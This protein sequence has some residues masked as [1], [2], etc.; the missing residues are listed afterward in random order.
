M[1]LEKNINKKRSVDEIISKAKEVHGDK[2]DYSLITREY[3]DKEKMPIL[4]HAISRDG[5][6]HGLFYQTYLSHVQTKCGCSKCGLEKRMIPEAEIIRRC[7]EVHGDKYDYSEAHP[8]S[9]H[10]KMTIIC[11]IHGRF[12][13]TPHDHINGKTECPKCKG[14][15]IWD[16]RGRFTVEHVKKQFFDV[17]GDL[18]DYSEF[19]EYTNNREKIPVICKKHGR[20]YVSANNHLRGRGCPKCAN[21]NNGNRCRLSTEEAIKRIKEIHG[22]RYIIP[23]DFKYISNNTKVKLICKE[24]GEFWQAPSALW[25]GVGCPK[26]NKSKLEVEISTFLTLNNI[27]HEEQKKFDWLGNYEL[28]FYLPEYNVAIECQGIQHFKPINLFGGEE[29]FVKQ[30]EWDKDK[31]RRCDENGIKLLYFTKKS[32]VNKIDNIEYDVITNKKTLLET[33]KNCNKSL[34]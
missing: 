24:H 34:L 9:T 13:A 23:D 15:K 7:K 19:T 20:F 17:Y 11:P 30:K 3:G 31:H 8:L 21:E 1:K 6:E 10:S 12:E 18:Y 29:Q 2:Y 22:D 27:N 25:I 26:C 33:I 28:D 32:V 5:N 16:K 4:C 14:N